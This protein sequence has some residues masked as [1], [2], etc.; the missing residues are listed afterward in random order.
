MARLAKVVQH[1]EKNALHVLKKSDG[2]M[3]EPGQETIDTLL[4]HH[5]P[6]ATDTEYETYN[7]RQNTSS[8]SILSKYSDWISE[9]FVRDALDGFEAKKSPGPDKLKP[10]ILSLIHI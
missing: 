6:S 1:N 8:S 10:L 5:F 7:N 3:T 4:G 9:D 2:T